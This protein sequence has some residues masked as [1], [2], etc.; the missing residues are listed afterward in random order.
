[1]VLILRTNTGLN[2]MVEHKVSNV[3]NKCKSWCKPTIFGCYSVEVLVHEI[4]SHIEYE[5]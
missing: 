3:V 5:V 1:M 2:N 4:T